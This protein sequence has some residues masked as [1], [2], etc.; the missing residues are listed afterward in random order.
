MNK[1]SVRSMLR[2]ARRTNPEMVS[3]AYWRKQIASERNHITHCLKNIRQYKQR[4]AQCQ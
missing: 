1:E 3:K 2:R 4:M